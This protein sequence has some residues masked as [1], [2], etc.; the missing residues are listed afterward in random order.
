LVA[1]LIFGAVDKGSRSWFRLPFFS[2]QPSEICRVALILVLANYLD[3][4]FSDI[5]KP[6][7]VMGALALVAPVFFLLMKQPDFSSMVTIFPVVIIMLYCAGANVFHLG[8]IVGYGFLTAFFPVAWTFISINPGWL[9]ITAVKW[10]YALHKLGAEAVFFCAGIF[11]A[12]Y[13]AWRLSVKFRAYIPP[14]Y[15][16]VAGLVMAGGFFSG[17]WVESQMKDYQRKRFE[18]FFAPK[19]DPKG[20]GYNILQAHIAMGSGGFAGKGIFSGTQARLGFVP[21]RHTDFILAV[22][23]EEMGFLGSISVLGLYLLML[24]RIYCAAKLSNDRFGYFTA[25]GIFGMFSVYM[26][27]NFGMSLGIMPVAG[28]PLPLVS[29]GGSN[30]AASLWSLGLAESIYARRVAL[31]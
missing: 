22:V 20:A 24:W 16:A 11:A 9:S 23:G 4:N 25:C 17:V 13:F 3:K 10:F 31:V 26:F 27:F 1:V 6:S 28:I 2:V 7:V 30:L 14:V 29:Y 8:A 19:A 5:R 18:V 15:F 21:E 12:V